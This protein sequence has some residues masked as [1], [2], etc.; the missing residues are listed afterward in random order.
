MNRAGES[1]VALE[2]HTVTKIYG[3]GSASVR[4]VDSVSFSVRA[5]EFMALV[6]PSGSGKTSMLAMLAGLLRPSEGRV[7]HRGPGPPRD[8]RRQPHTLSREGDRVCISV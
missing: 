6:G 7:F 1:G 2:A 5:G 8:E 3:D 4:A